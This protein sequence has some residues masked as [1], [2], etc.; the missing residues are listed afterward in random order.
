[1]GERFPQYLSAP[2]QVLWFET[3]EL[4]IIVLFFLLA[5]I[6]HGILWV[7]CIVGPFC[8]SQMKAKYPSSFLQHMLY[9]SG[10]KTIKHYPNSFAN[11]FNE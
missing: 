10:I 9:F 7:L 5:S 2:V 8:Y 6:F 4:A 11:T 3:D 1:M